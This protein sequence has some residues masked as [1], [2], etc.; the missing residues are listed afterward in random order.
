MRSRLARPRRKS[1]EKAAGIRTHGEGDD[2]RQRSRG[3]GPDSRVAGARRSPSAPKDDRHDR[4][5][6]REPADDGGAPVATIRIQPACQEERQRAEQAPNA[7]GY[8][9]VNDEEG[10]RQERGRPG[11]W[12]P[13]A[14]GSGGGS[15]QA[16]RTHDVVL[17]D[18]AVVGRKIH[19]RHAQDR[20][21][22]E[23]GVLAPNR[24]EAHAEGEDLGKVDPEGEE[25]AERSA[26]GSRLP[27]PRARAAIAPEVFGG[28][29]GPDSMWKK[30]P[31]SRTVREVVHA[32]GGKVLVDPEG[33]QKCGRDTPEEEEE[34]EWAR[35]AR[36]GGSSAACGARTRRGGDSALSARAVVRA[37]P[38][39]DRSHGVRPPPPLHGSG[40]GR[41]TF[42]RCPC[43][44]SD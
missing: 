32:V 38:A 8:D 27:G 16:R 42:S 9:R 14:G 4:E 12:A 5:H 17:G 26:P 6:E 34:Q 20:Q 23:R 18:Q 3:T 40:R 25:R 28:S 29:C 35:R 1:T 15:A 7:V 41:H 31:E 43:R 19:A 21:R 33:V 37:P 13:L 24:E 2:R 39:F 36:G 10:Q 30:S 22:Q 44:I 11:R